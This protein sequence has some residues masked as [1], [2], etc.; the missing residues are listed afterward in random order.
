MPVR[1]VR[2]GHACAPWPTIACIAA[3]KLRTITV[4]FPVRDAASV[5]AMT[6]QTLG[7]PNGQA[8]AAMP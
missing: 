2:G 8:P 4:R 5:E 7:V 1:L 3:V 6:D